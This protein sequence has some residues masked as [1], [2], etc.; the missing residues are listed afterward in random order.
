[1]N[2]KNTCRFP[3]IW[4]TTSTLYMY[5][6]ACAADTL[7]RIP[8]TLYHL[9]R[10]KTHRREKRK[11]RGVLPRR[12]MN[13]NH[14]QRI[15][16][17]FVWR[18]KAATSKRVYRILISS[19]QWVNI[20][21]VCVTTFCVCPETRVYICLPNKTPRERERKN[22]LPQSFVMLMIDVYLH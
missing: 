17:G 1:M 15:L 22:Y 14:S 20:G 3:L 6:Y 2:E 16:L 13:E 21:A 12:L 4:N 9:Q 11:I 8:P 10:E 5:V 18:F 7:K 19:F